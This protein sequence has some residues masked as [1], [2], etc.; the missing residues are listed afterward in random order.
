MWERLWQ[1]MRIG[2]GKGEWGGI[3]GVGLQ[4]RWEGLAK[5]LQVELASCNVGAG[6][7]A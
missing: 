7:A 3:M 6:P 1:E 4:S 2:G 5:Q